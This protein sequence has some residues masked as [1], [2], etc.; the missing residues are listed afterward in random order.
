MNTCDRCD[1]DIELHREAGTNRTCRRCSCRRT[2]WFIAKKAE[3][4]GR[5]SA[6]DAVAAALSELIEVAQMYRF[7]DHTGVP[8]DRLHEAELAGREALARF[9]GEPDAEELHPA[10]PWNDTL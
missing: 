2:Q 6:C 4:E 3:Q 8:A 5:H 10:A 1:H 7:S 9:R